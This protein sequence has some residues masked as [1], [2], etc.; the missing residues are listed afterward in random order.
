LSIITNPISSK[1][2][3]PNRV[4]CTRRTVLLVT[5]QSGLQVTG[6]LTAGASD[7]KTRESLAQEGLLRSGEADRAKEVRKE[8]Q[9]S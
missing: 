9:I 6:E 8:F 3:I 5:V 4:S 1:A 2:R 7:K